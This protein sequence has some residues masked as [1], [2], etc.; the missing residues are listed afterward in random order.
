MA[1]PAA[2]TG[3]PETLVKVLF[4]TLTP[5]QRE[6]ICFDW[7]YQDKDRGLLRTRVANNWEITKNYI[8][9]KQFYTDDQRKIVRSIFGNFQVLALLVGE[10]GLKR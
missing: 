1:S 10:F 6:S 5:K 3:A 9:D 2:A 8:N 4:D 7:D